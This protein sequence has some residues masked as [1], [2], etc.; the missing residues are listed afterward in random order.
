M[1]GLD[2]LGTIV[3]RLFIFNSRDTTIYCPGNPELPL[4]CAES[5]AVGCTTSA[6]ET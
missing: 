4:I 6:A 5:R 3:L 2:I 1:L